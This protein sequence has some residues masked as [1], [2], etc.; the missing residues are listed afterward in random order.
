MLTATKIG[1]FSIVNI[2]NC[3][4]TP[5]STQHSQQQLTAQQVFS[6]W[7]T[8]SILADE[9]IHVTQE[10]C[11]DLLAW[12]RAPSWRWS[13]PSRASGFGRLFWVGSAG[14]LTG[15]CTSRAW[16]LVGM[17]GLVHGL[18]GMTDRW[19]MHLRLVR[20]FWYRAHSFS[21]TSIHRSHQV[22]DV[23]QSRRT[24]GVNPKI[25]AA[26]PVR[27]S[28]HIFTWTRRKRRPPLQD[29]AIIVPVLEDRWIIS[30]ARY[31]ALVLEDH[32][33]PP[34]TTRAIHN[35]LAS[36][37]AAIVAMVRHRR[38]EYLQMCVLVVNYS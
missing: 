10:W 24:P 4:Y 17:C 37:R 12:P 28:V 11:R 27:A 18:M 19:W 20:S 35:C 8:D 31:N 2:R 14:R 21:R 5:I 22:S 33:I 36:S 6:T 29:N 23:P 38:R 1:S 7:A 26:K 15:S 25:L 3:Q 13:R 16:E 34:L 32:L 9:S 30:N